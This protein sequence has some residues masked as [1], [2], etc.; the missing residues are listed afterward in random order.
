MLG[1]VLLI[2]VAWLPHARTL[3]HGLVWDDRYLVR[4]VETAALRGGLGAVAAAPFLPEQNDPDNYYRPVVNLSLWLDERVG[5]GSAAA[6]HATNLLLHAINTLLVARL[7]LLL[8]GGGA[9]PMLG[10]A[11]FA[12]HPVQVESVAFAA[13]RT[14]LWA[15]CFVLLATLA[16]LASRREERPPRRALLL[17]GAAGAY[18]AGCLAK[19]TA[20]VLPV[21]LAA[22]DAAGL[23]RRGT[24]PAGWLE[25]NGEAALAFAMALA[26]VG[27][28]RT[29]V[30]GA[31]LVTGGP[32]VAIQGPLAIRE[33]GLA[34]AA[35]VRLLALLVVPWPLSSFIRASTW[36]S[37]RR[38]HWP[39]GS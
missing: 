39:R 6:Y 29:L 2:L 4:D 32:A 12:V 23:D 27:W 7:L 36:R 31:V 22:L 11:V 26:L 9:G 33:P 38:A 24:S 13:A 10:A 20:A 5:G 35:F 37:T 34:L 17:A 1:V 30:L 18:V 19:E 14:D 25:R 16:W 3:G 28:I 21:A 15:T 8:L